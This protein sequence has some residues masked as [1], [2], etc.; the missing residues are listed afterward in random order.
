[1]DNFR[2]TFPLNEPA[3]TR[4][5]LGRLLTDPITWVPLIPAVAAY[6]IFDMPALFSLVLGAI[7]LGGVG[8]FWRKQWNGITEGLRRQAIE[9]HNRAQNAILKAGADELRLA[10]AGKYAQQ[11]EE[12]LAIKSKVEQRLHEDGHITAQKV[13]LEQLIDSLC[14]GVRDQLTSLAL[15]EKKREPV[16]RK[17]ALAQ[18]DSAFET[19]ETT[20][21]ELD[22]ILGPTVTPGGTANASLEEITRRLREEA[23]I[24]RRVQARLRAQE[25]EPTSIEFPGSRDT[26]T[27]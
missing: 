18:V 8:A 27:Q 25:A 13:Q 5:A 1:M 6:T 21:A 15:K 17:A 16:D 2:S 11:L 20:V 26:E 10:G 7:A 22:T 9:N 24:A 4:A 23:E 3:I 12:F 14:F 19:L